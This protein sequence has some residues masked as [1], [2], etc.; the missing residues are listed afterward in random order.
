[1]WP[2]ISRTSM[3][4]LQFLIESNCCDWYWTKSVLIGLFV[5]EMPLLS[6]VSSFMVIMKILARKT[7]CQLRAY[8][9]ARY[10][11]P[12]VEVV[13]LLKNSVIFYVILLVALSRFYFIDSVWLVYWPLRKKLTFLSNTLF[14]NLT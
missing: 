8:M 3:E 13:I 12:W 6:N 9:L 7:L 11:M 10:V 5:E 1:M 2:S 14:P 4:K